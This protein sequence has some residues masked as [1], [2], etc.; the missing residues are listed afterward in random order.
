V[1]QNAAS[2]VF[3][4]IFALCVSGALLQTSAAAQMGEGMVGWN[5]GTNTPDR[6]GSA[7]EACEFQWNYNGHG[8]LSRFIAANVW[9][10]NANGANCSW[11]TYQYLCPEETGGG[12]SGCGTILP[13]TVWLECES[14]YQIILGRCEKDPTPERPCNCKDQ[15]NWPGKNET[16]GHPI[17]LSTGAKVLTAQDYASADGEFVI[18]RSY[19][20]RQ[21]GWSASVQ[22]KTVGLAGG[23]NF[24]FM[25]EIQ[26]GAFSGSPTSPAA[27]LALLA[28]DGSAYDFVMQSGGTWVPD[29]TTGAYYAPTNIKVEYVGTL[30]SDLGTLQSAAT[31]WKVTDGNDTIWTF[32]TFTRPNTTSPYSIGRPTVR[33]ARS[34]YRWDLAYRSDNS[35]QTVTD[36]FGRVA[37]FNWSTYYISALSSPPSGSAPYPEAVSS[38]S[39]PDGT[40]LRYTFDPAPATAAPSTGKVQR[41][42]KVERL[43]ASSVAIDSTTYAYGDARFPTYLTAVTN[44]NSDQVASY[45][46]DPAGRAITSALANGVDQYTVASTESPTEI[47]RT[48]TGPLGKV[49]DHHFARFGSGTQDIRPSSVVG[50]ASVNTAPSTRSTTYDSNN[51]IATETDE[52]GRVTS[53]TRD[54]R[55]RPTTIT[56]AYGTPQQRSTTVTWHST[57]NVPSQIVR[58]GL[59][60]DYTYSSTGQLLTRTET[61]TTSQSIPYSTNGQSRTWTYTWGPGGRVAS[62]NGPK[63]VDAAGKDDTLTFAYD[64]SGSL[65]TSTNGLGQVTSFANY[66]ANGRPGTMTDANGVVSAFTYDAMGLVRTITVRH[67]TTGSLDAVTTIDYDTVGRVTGLTLPSTEKLFMDYDTADRL[68]AMRAA[69]GERRDYVY[70]SKGNVTMETVKRA[71]T[72]LAQQ[73]SRT[74]DELGRQMTE[75]LGPRRTSALGYDKVGNVT[76]MRTPNG[77]ATTQAFDALNRL[78]TTV[79]PD[80]GTI[81][82]DYDVRDNLTSHTDPISVATQF[83]RNGFGDAIQEVS[84]DRGTSVYYYNEAGELTAA[85]DGRGQRVE[86]TRDILGRVTQKAP[87]GRP[88]SETITYAWNTPGISGSYGVGRL[89]S[90]SD[91]TGTTSFA[92]DHRGNLITKRQTIGSGTA[93]LAFAYDLADRVTEITYPSGRVVQYTYDTKGRVSQVQTKA[94]A[95]APSWTVLA[96]DMSYEPFGSVKAMAFGNGLSVVNDWGNDGRLAS[97]RLY[98]T[99]GGTNLSWLTYGYDGNDNIGAIRDQLDDANSAYYGYD[100]ND[101]MILT[102]RVVASPAASTETLSYTSGTNR[103]AS[104]VNAAGTRSIGYDGRGNTLSETRPGG[105]S[106]SATYDGYSRLLTYTRTGDPAQTNAYNGLDDRVS[107]TSASTTHTFVY[108]PD[109]RVLGEYGASASDVI[110]EMIWLGPEV[111]NVNQPFG[112]D[113]GVGGYAPLAVATGSGASAVLTW[114]HGNHLGVPI[115]FT[116]TS[117]AAVTAPSYTLPGFPGQMRTLSD[118]YYNRYRDYDSSTGRYIEADPIG[119]EGGSNLYLYAGAN[120]LRWMD[121]W[122]LNPAAARGAIAVGELAGEGF[123]WWCRSNV[124][125]CART[126]GP[127]IVRAANACNALVKALT[128]DDDEEDCSKVA[129]TWELQ[130]AGINPH[131]VKRFLG[132]MSDYEICKCRP[133]GRFV[134]RRKGCTGP[135]IDEVFPGDD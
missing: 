119:L 8:Y 77:G 60:I 11:T 115:A 132:K 121:P 15:K 55:G 111:T 32:Q 117:G 98:Q 40:S 70:D 69:N 83:V 20:S 63:P 89:S 104:I 75:A 16:K 106:V 80:S 84:P 30:P 51:F 31:Q 3:S 49:E 36:S 94:S 1:L 5:A 109:G 56:E 29:T 2:A 53:Y 102:S 9:G 52:E 128:G 113:D 87:T 116:D 18:G 129:T 74:F 82:R 91:G 92:Y 133:S 126:I 64:T 67:P 73:I 95:G 112:G 86:Y 135:I 41:L 130:Q 10:G 54:S 122:G 134:I 78:V 19:R 124:A 21:F 22:T 61:D 96:S 85:I 97:R 27:K 118:I 107:A 105:A 110:A 90:I 14:G 6:F 108:A 101:R 59:Q 46:Y 44:F 76:L 68:V 93:D 47:V 65:Q 38:V 120:P 48:V 43:S 13:A 28:P 17:V 58:P 57:Y 72:T 39:L 33:V 123:V 81:A 131:K 7:T 34:G 35:L 71:D 79:A 114:L 103:L 24:D 50:Q 23:W 125:L 62:I 42:I 99:S 37:T 4:F 88:A 127:P 26:L 25:Y 100:A 12:I 66:D 45:S